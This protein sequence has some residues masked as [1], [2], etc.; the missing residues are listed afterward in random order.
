[1]GADRA[2]VLDM[3]GALKAIQRFVDR[4]TQDEF[5][6]DDF[7]QAAVLHKFT[8]LGAACRRVSAAYREAHPEV[9]WVDITDFRNQIVHEYD[10]IQL[11]TV[12]TI[13][14]RDVPRAIASLE[15]LVPEEPPDGEEG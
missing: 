8:I 5:L 10:E 6:R 3:L 14:V 7:F 15:P 2:A 9:Q 13:V 12:W 4:R 1:M 11:D